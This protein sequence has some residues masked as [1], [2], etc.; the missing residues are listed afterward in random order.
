[1][2][3]THKIRAHGG[4]PDTPSRSDMKELIANVGIREVLQCIADVTGKA[5]S[6]HKHNKKGCWE[7]STT[8]DP[9]PLT[10]TL[11]RWR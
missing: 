8:F 10:H 7:D 3:K 5:I 2:K 6:L 1:M 11:E 4:P 9:G